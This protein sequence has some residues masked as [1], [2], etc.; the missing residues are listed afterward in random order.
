[1]PRRF[2]N[3]MN[4]SRSSPSSPAALPAVILRSAKRAKIASFLRCSASSTLSAA[5]SATLTWISSLMA[6]FIVPLY[7]GLVAPLAPGLMAS[8]LKQALQTIGESPYRRARQISNCFKARTSRSSTRSRTLNP[9]QALGLILV[10]PIVFPRHIVLGDFFRVNLSHV[11]V[12][13]VFHAF[14]RFGLEV[15]S[16]LDQFFYALRACFRHVRQSLRIPGLPR[17]PGPF[18]LLSGRQGVVLSFFFVVLFFHPFLGTPCPANA[19][20]RGKRA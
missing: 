7:R 18:P 14:D 11:R 6:A 20:T 12:R 17:R 15:L 5:S 13:S 19:A 9:N 1:M 2:S 10:L 8:P 16:L 4:A 3:S